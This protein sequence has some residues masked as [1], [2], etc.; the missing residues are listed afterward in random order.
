V[1]FVRRCAPYAVLVA[2]ALWLCRLYEPFDRAITIDNQLYIY[3]AE[4]VAAGVPPHVSL[5]D[6]KHALSAMLSGWAMWVGRAVGIDDVH[7][8][9]I[10][11]M[12]MAATLPAAL[13]AVAL[14]LTGRTI[15]AHI[16][17]FVALTF[18][19]FFAQSAMGVRPQLFMA[20]FM[21][22]SFAALGARRHAIAGGAAIASFL[23]WQPA[24]L[25]F[26][27]SCVAIAL[28][29]SSLRALVRYV[30]GGLVVL[31]LYEA[32]FWHHGALAEQLFQSYRM[33]SDLGGYK[34]E[35][36]SK[37]ILFV[38][39]DGRWGAGWWVVVPAVYLAG[40]ALLVAEPLVRWRSFWAR[41]RSNAL[42]GALTATSVL[43][44]A[45]TL[46]DHQ[47]YPDRFFLQPFIALANGLAFGLPIAW[48]CDRG[49]RTGR[50]GRPERV[51]QVVSAAIFAAGSL[52]VAT[53][54]VTWYPAERVITLAKQREL[55]NRAA[56]LRRQYG[57]VWAIGCPHVLALKRTENFDSIGIVIDPKV[58]HY[59]A[60]M[61]GDDGYRP[62]NGSM[63]VVMLTSRGGEGIAF[64]WLRREYWPV[65]DEEFKAHG[66]NTWLRKECLVDRKCRAL[67]DCAIRPQCRPRVSR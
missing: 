28:E 25:V 30:A 38:L 59:M 18:D 23:C 50:L 39:R 1:L 2:L 33:P 45:F 62:R 9:R 44:L 19:D 51:G 8:A 55:A 48:L 52:L 60:S 66:I 54:N 26:A 5:V 3:V 14:Q 40:L 32:Y 22:Y 34:Y 56:A 63:P 13:W 36:L 49:G 35:P 46:I 24:L 65:R 64:P 41:L 42:P 61:G 17:A 67:F 29:R 37:G 27:S 4:R 10:L 15:V 20:V 11:S 6:H 12:G 21:A 16:A 53:N 7:S 31:L 47:A 58:R 43:A 57:P